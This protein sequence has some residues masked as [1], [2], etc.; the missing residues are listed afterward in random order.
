MTQAWRW[1]SGKKTYLMAIAVIA[2]QV[3]GHFANG[4][5]ID[6]RA[7]ETAILAATIRHGISTTRG[8]A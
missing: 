3:G 8:G 7:I 4:T 6:Y 2:Y 1:L 5:P